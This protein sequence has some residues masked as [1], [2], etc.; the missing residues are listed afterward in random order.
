[1]AKAAHLQHMR[2]QHIHSPCLAPHFVL[3]G[4]AASNQ[5]PFQVRRCGTS[6]SR[7]LGVGASRR[8]CKAVCR[9]VG[10]AFVE[11]QAGVRMGEQAAARASRRGVRGAGADGR[12]GRGKVGP[13]R[14]FCSVTVLHGCLYNV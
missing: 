2:N 5:A 13:W 11:P 4:R 1:M 7:R 12:K 10:S 14:Y 8:L 3:D 9:L 6:A